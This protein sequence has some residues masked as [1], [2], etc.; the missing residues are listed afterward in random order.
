MRSETRLAA[1]RP[2]ETPAQQTPFKLQG[3][4]PQEMLHGHSSIGGRCI[5]SGNLL[6]AAASPRCSCIAV[7]KGRSREHR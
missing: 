7:S 2:P 5:C 6:R 4:S 3:G 1:C